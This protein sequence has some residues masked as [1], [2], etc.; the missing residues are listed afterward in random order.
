M[1]KNR[2]ENNI[3][4]LLDWIY[5]FPLI[6]HLDLLIRSGFASVFTLAH[7]REAQATIATSFK[8]GVVTLD[9]TTHSWLALIRKLSTAVTILNAIWN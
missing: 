9:W 8:I 4:R 1:R 6:L 2:M 5:P 7:P 3:P